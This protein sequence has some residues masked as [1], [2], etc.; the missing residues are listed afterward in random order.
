MNHQ[1]SKSVLVIICLAVIAALSSVIA[2]DEPAKEAPPKFTK[3]YLT[4]SKN[5]EVG[6]A[7]WQDQCRHCHGSSAYPG[8]APK[9]KP[10]RYKPAFVYDRVTNGFEKMPAWKEI[11]S[12]KE[13]MAVVAYILSEDFSP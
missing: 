3:A 4:D 2:A 1:M 11:Y 6:R 7:I 9:L 8:K 12:K 13:R 5:Q 10:Y